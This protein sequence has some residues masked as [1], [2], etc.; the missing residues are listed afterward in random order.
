MD[1][2]D[3]NST[4]ASI[5]SEVDQ[6]VRR[7]ILLRRSGAEVLLLQHDSL[8]T[9]PSLIIPRYQR[10]AECVTLEV[11]KRF[12]ISAY[13]L[14]ST[15]IPRRIT[16]SE[17]EA[18]CCFYDVM[19]CLEKDQLEPEECVWCSAD[20]LAQ[21]LLPEDTL[22]AVRSAINTMREYVNAPAT[23]PFGRPGWL[24]DISGRAGKDIEPLGLRLSGQFKQFNSSPTFALVR[25]ETDGPA[26][27]L[28]AVGEPNIREF[29]ITQ[30]IAELFP[31]YAP[32]VISTMPECHGWL[33][34]EIEGMELSQTRDPRH[35]ESAAFAL[36]RLQ[37]DSIGKQ[38]VL[39]NA[40]ARDLRA[41]VLVRVVEPFLLV[42]TQ[43]MDEQLSVPPVRLTKAEI[44]SLGG[45]LQRAFS[46]LRDSGIPETLGH[47]D[48][49][50][51][52]IIASPEGCRFLDWAE[53]YVGFPFCS[54]EYLRRHFQR[55]LGMDRHLEVRLIAAYTKPWLAVAAPETI[56]IAQTLAPMLAVFFFAA[57]TDAWHD[58]DRL[59]DPKTAAYL[60]G[61]TRR[62]RR[63]A[64]ELSS[65][66]S[67]CLSL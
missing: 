67:R 10:V 62:L 21:G 61:L 4:P 47:L 43:L 54:F 12:G 3:S 58:R 51:G 37:I 57:G 17:G 40:G 48:L 24:Q 23:G 5:R 64:D 1:P 25:F 53:A 16:A 33:S 63:E 32:A 66:R 46:L 49:G 14:F 20:P 65:G 39:L 22:E 27:W 9:L 29:P 50:P 52:N 30:A 34:P 28:K 26:I 2:V 15:A 11:E 19:A 35:W 38:H 44:S 55:Y 59:R 8:C 36:A 42:M 41:E 31:K 60:R 18:D 6:E 45:E 7:L 56:A 13:C